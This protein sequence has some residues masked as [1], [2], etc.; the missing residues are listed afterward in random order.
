MI[1]YDAFRLLHSSGGATR[2]A[3][4]TA[5]PELKSVQY[6]TDFFEKLEART[7]QLFVDITP[8]RDRWEEWKGT[9][10]IVLDHHESVEAITRGLGGVYATNDAHSGA[11]LAYEHVLVP[12]TERLCED[13]D[14]ERDSHNVIRSDCNHALARWDEFSRLAMIRDTWKD[15]D[16]DFGRASVQAYGLMTL[17]SKDLLD[18]LREGKFDPDLITRMGE[19]DYGRAKFV[20]DS[21]RR[22]EVPCPRLGRP[23]LVDVYNCTEKKLISDGCHHLLNEK[24][25]DLA[26]SYFLK[27]QDGKSSAVVSLR[28]R[29]AFAGEVAKSLGGGGHANAAGF[30]LPDGNSVTMDGLVSVLQERLGLLQ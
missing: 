6:N 20:A 27:H 13:L 25:A 24:G 23:A 4:T 19:K 26:V 14:P 21:A 16:P 11:R 12:I 22:Y 30:G 5:I 3:T 9:G 15:E 18:Q 1:C 2:S 8:P 29:A 28:T 17:G 10:V 7:G